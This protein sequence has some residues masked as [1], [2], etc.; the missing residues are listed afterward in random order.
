MQDATLKEVGYFDSTYKPSIS[1]SGLKLEVI[2]YTGFVG[3][4]ETVFDEVLEPESGPLDQPN[5][6]QTYE[7]ASQETQPIST[8][9]FD[10]LTS[11]ERTVITYL[12]NKGLN[13]AI[14]CGICAN[15]KAESNFRTGAKGDKNTSFGICQWHKGR[16]EAMKNMVGEGW[17][18]NLS[19][20]LDYLWSELCGSY[21][22]V[23]NSLSGCPNTVEGA[24]QAAD[25][26]V[27]K[28]EVPSNVDAAS[29]KRQISAAE[30]YNKIIIQL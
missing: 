20:Q 10:G 7:V 28:F 23:L 24:K 17:E 21:K 3:E 18:N 19:G 13:P 29:T 11:A 26:F 30:Y 6:I 15:I 22:F 12:I 8:V 16:G 14:A 4:V 25:I 27:R 9:A 5:T 1:P 2:N